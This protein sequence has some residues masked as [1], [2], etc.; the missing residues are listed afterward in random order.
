MPNRS[1]LRVAVQTVILV[2]VLA[3]GAEAG[4]MELISR[5]APGSPAA[6][7]NGP[8]TAAALSRDGDIVLFLSRANGLVPGQFDQSSGPGDELGNWD[9][10]LRDRRAGKTVLL[11]RYDDGAYKAEAVGG[12]EPTLSADGR[13]AAFV[14]REDL[15]T[16]PPVTLW[17]LYLY[18]RTTDT[19]TLVNHVPGSADTPDGGAAFQPTLSADGRYL[20][21]ACERCGLIPGHPTNRSEIFLY[22]RVTGALSLVTPAT[23]GDDFSLEPRISAD[24]RFVAFR[25][26]AT[27]LIPG[28]TDIPGT[29]DLFLFDRTTGGLA[30]VSHAPGSATAAQG[31]VLSVGLSGDGNFIAF[32]SNSDSLIPGQVDGNGLPDLFLYDR[33]SGTNVLV[34][35]VASSPVTAGNGSA[36]SSF[37]DVALSADGR[38]IAFAS[39]STD[40]LFE[41]DDTNDTF[42]V[43]LYDRVT[44]ITQLLSTAPPSGQNSAPFRTPDGGATRP[45]ISAD[46]SRVAFV[47]APDAS[48]SA[49]L[50]VLD[51]TSGAKTRVGRVHSAAPVT[52]NPPISFEPRLSENGRFVAFTSDSDQ[53]V[54]GDLN[55]N[56]DVYLFD[57]G[58]PGSN[59]LQPCKLL[60]TR[61]RAE[62]PVLT[63]NVRRD[64]PVFGRCG[65][66]ATAKQIVVKV[67]VFNPSGKGNLRFYPGAVTAAP[68]GILRFERGAILTESFTLPLGTNGRLTI[69][70]YVAGKGKVHAAVEVSGYLE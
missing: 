45:A 17:R 12:Q 25:S 52:T 51:R 22:D 38:F 18:D 66:P 62:R 44:G 46:G 54:P 41:I 31:G 15:V 49:D 7:P 37:A 3:M 6:T 40:L 30:L 55:A 35:H 24:G 8:S 68:S 23:G 53:F 39:A 33:A 16:S 57:S 32:T 5:S 65:V 58:Q 59:P 70:P 21:F 19:R 67:T 36:L 11:S 64:L 26:Y 4:S 20:A 43:F 63:S 69:L 29:S 50:F 48:S 61:R 56:W 28:Q 27:N 13:F 47:S 14:T 60:D 34:S 42:D 9:V 2:L 1:A 10:F